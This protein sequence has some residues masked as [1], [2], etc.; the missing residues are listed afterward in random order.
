LLTG[1]ANSDYDPYADDIRAVRVQAAVLLPGV[2]LALVAQVLALISG[3]PGR[4]AG[5]TG[6][7]NA[8]QHGESWG[9]PRVADT[10]SDW[11][12]RMGQARLRGRIREQPPFA[13][14][15]L[16]LLAIGLAG[17]LF[18]AVVRECGSTVWGAIV[19][20]GVLLVWFRVWGVDDGAP[21]PSR[22]SGTGLDTVSLYQRFD[23]A[24][25]GDGYELR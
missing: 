10:G 2:S 14:M 15:S 3:R 23:S 16:V 6:R 7:R 20:L 25:A 11:L 9:Q 24:R 13:G 5:A 22:R 1:N 18:V 19:A 8:H 21:R 17:V 12:A 4:F